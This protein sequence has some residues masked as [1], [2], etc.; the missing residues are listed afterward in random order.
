MNGRSDLQSSDNNVNSGPEERPAVTVL[1]RTKNEEQYIGRTLSV[2]FSQTYKEFEVLIVDSGSTDKTLEVAKQYPVRIYEIKPEEFTYGYSLNY[3]FQR[4]SGKYVVNLSAHALP[5]SDDWLETL[6]ADCDDERV[7]AVMSN[8]LPCPDC[9]PFDKRGLLKK[10]NIPKQEISGGPPYIFANYGSVIRRSVWE[11]VHYNE[12]LSYAEDHDW[13]LRVEALGYKIIYEP[14][15]KTY[16][17]HN[18]TLRQIYRRSYMEASARKILKFKQYTLINLLY[19]LLAGS[20][21]DM[22]Y[23]LYKREPLKWFLFAPLRRCAM[24]YGRFKASRSVDKK[25]GN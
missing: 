7:A 2:I 10:F 17:S 5:L 3:G 16:H 15:A 24:N 12:T 4:A 8:N 22:L 1:I 23:V 19:D 18:E 25:E 11:K 13:A 14:D 20:I 9:N 6:I 21:Y